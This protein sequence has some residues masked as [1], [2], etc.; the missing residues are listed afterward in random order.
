M[1][2]AQLDW[3]GPVEQGVAAV[4]RTVGSEK[5]GRG[6]G[7]KVTAGHKP[8]PEPW[9]LV[10]GGWRDP[11]ILGQALQSPL[12]I[13]SGAPEHVVDSPVPQPAPKGC[14]LERICRHM[15]CF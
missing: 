15:D 4:A 12:H 3:E 10:P 9:L 1:G 13:V 2:K 14:H 11:G 5:Q 6:G 8:L 7:M